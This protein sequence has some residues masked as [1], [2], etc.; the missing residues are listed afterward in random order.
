[1]DGPQAKYG[2]WILFGLAALSCTGVF[3]FSIGLISKT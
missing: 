3:C 1:M 2:P